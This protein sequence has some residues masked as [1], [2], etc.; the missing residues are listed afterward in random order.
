MLMVNVVTIASY[1]W[2]SGWSAWSNGRQPPG[3]ACYIRQMKRV[4]SRSG[5]A[6]MT[7]PQTLALLLLLLLLLLSICSDRTGVF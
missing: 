7:A 5:S 4:N 6:M 2:I 3:A 1:R